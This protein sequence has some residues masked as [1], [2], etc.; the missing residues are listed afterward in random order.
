MGSAFVSGILPALAAIVSV[1]ITLWFENKR[2]LLATLR[3]LKT[4]MKHNDD[5]GE[6]TLHDL[7]SD[8]SAGYDTRI[9]WDT[10]PLQT[11]AYNNFVN[12][13]IAVKISDDLEDIIWYHYLIV[14]KVN[15]AISRRSDATDDNELS[16]YEDTI[17]RGILDL[18][19]SSRLDVMES[20]AHDDEIREVVQEALNAQKKREASSDPPRPQTYDE[21]ISEIED[22]VARKHW[23]PASIYTRL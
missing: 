6:S 22:E 7:F 18:S 11:S 17:L 4:E 15:R 16:D 19:A 3:A 5:L 12:S 1:F 21:V 8:T 13:G 20:N 23:L 9:R 10:V 2:R 14:K